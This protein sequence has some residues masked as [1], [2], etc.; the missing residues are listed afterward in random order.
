MNNIDSKQGSEKTKLNPILLGVIAVLVCII[1]VLIVN[2]RGNQTTASD[3][4]KLSNTP[5]FSD[6]YSGEE[7]ERWDPNS[8]VY[9][10]YKYGFVW[11]LPSDIK[12]DYVAGTS[13]HTIFKVV[14]PETQ[15]T[16]YANVSTIEGVDLREV[17]F[18]DGFEMMKIARNEAIKNMQSNSGNKISNLSFEKCT[19][20]NRHA[21]KEY[22]EDTMDDDRYDTPVQ[23][24]AISYHFYHYNYSFTITVK[25]F[26]EIYEVIDNDGMMNF[27]KGFNLIPIQ[28]QD[29]GGDNKDLKRI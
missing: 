4:D 13:Q 25:C 23:T 28:E 27:F 1:L 26:K 7:I 20:C 2:N 10:N 14:D 11:V 3:P 22:F 24:S 16:A 21:A 5:T 9:S 19:F 12:W 6:L 15:I 8:C 18:W 29:K 17:D